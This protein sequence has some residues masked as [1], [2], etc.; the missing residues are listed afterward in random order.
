MHAS[1]TFNI[2]NR[3]R[4]NATGTPQKLGNK[5]L[6]KIRTCIYLSLAEIPSDSVRLNHSDAC[7][8]YQLETM[9]IVCLKS[10]DKTGTPPI[11]C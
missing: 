1:L 4:T 5:F 8:K 3:L 10:P 6:K 7:K 11:G 2:I 9:G